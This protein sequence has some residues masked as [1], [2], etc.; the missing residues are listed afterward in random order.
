[1]SGGALGVAGG[2]EWSAGTK[3]S[4]AKSE[5]RVTACKCLDG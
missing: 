2:R 5:L 3:T 1:M 4:S